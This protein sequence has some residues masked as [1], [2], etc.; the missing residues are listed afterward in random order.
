MSKTHVLSLALLTLTALTSTTH[1]AQ[2]YSFTRLVDHVDDNFSPRT[3]TSAS[4]NAAGDVAF[5]AAP[6]TAQVSGGLV[7]GE[8]QRVGSGRCGCRGVG[9][10][11]HDTPMPGPLALGDSTGEVATGTSPD[12]AAARP[13]RR[14]ASTA[15][16]MPTAVRE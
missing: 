5:D 9:K 8:Q 14:A 7:E 16:L 2:R 6:G 3:I 4:I 1:A 10:G 15:D 11:L 12:V 13:R